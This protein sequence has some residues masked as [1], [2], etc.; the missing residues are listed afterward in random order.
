MCQ[1]DSDSFT[2]YRWQTN[3]T[4]KQEKQYKTY[5]PQC[6][7]I[8]L[9]KNNS[10][11]TFLLLESDYK[12]VGNWTVDNSFDAHFVFKNYQYSDSRLNTDIML[13]YLPLEF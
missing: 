10:K 13:T 8:K 7:R 9:F 1:D 11:S 4:L 12:F 5:L 6:E 3:E 2:M